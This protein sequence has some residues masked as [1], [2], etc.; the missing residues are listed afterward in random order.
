[1]NLSINT[2][3]IPNISKLKRER[4]LELQDALQE[5]AVLGKEALLA[6][7]NELLENTTSYLDEENIRRILY[8]VQEDKVKNLRE[9][10]NVF[11]SHVERALEGKQ[12]GMRKRRTYRSRKNR[13]SHSRKNRSSRFSRRNRNRRS[14]KA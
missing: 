6:I 14:L 4:L 5:D 8:M 7:G 1:M 3:V 13:T 9:V 2:G 10:Q 11:S 12:G